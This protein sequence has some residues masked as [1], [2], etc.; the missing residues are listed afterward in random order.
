MGYSKGV[1]SF[2]ITLFFVIILGIFIYIISSVFHSNRA[3]KENY[4]EESSNLVD[5]NEEN[6]TNNNTSANS[7]NDPIINNEGNTTNN[8]NVEQPSPAPV[9]R[10]EE[11]IKISSYSTAI[12]DNAKNRKYNLKLAC[13][14]LNGYVI[15]ANHEFSFNEALGPM[16]KDAGYK[17]ATGFDSNGNNIKVYAGGMCQLSSTTYNTALIA[18]LKITERHA[19]SKRVSYVP[20]GKD[21]TIYYGSLDLKFINTNDFD[22]EIKA[23]S[24]GGKVTV[25]MY[26]IS[27]GIYS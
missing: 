4:V 9:K 17:K 10:T 13:S 11:K 7:N 23:F 21:A 14:K 2:F 1:E 20:K 22:I 19:H 6:N 18:K 24:N 16:G 15:K 12:Y 8:E 25:E 26:K 5:N 27:S 3:L